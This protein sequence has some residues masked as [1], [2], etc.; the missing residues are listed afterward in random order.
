MYQ[1][2]HELQPTNRTWLDRLLDM[3]AGEEAGP[4]NR[5]ALI[6]ENCYAHNGLAIPEE[7]E[8]LS[9][10]LVSTQQFRICGG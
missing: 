9:K 5:F 10:F 8:T 3:I 4:S 1:R 7:F 6:C 2:M